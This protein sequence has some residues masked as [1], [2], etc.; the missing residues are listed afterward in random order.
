LSP[1]SGNGRSSSNHAPV[2]PGGRRRR[3]P[4]EA[5]KAHPDKPGRKLGKDYGS[6]AFRRLP[7]VRPD[8]II[9][10]PLAWR[11]PHCGAR[12]KE[13]YVASQFQT[14][15]PRRS[16]LRRFD[17]HIGEFM[18]CGKR[19]QPRHELRTSDTLG[20]AAVQIGPDAQALIA[21]LKA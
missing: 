18:S 13:D 8:E 3:S 17:L 5:P 21:L 6:Q 19:V 1:A 7:R 11:C 15:I 2:T 16:L 10:V 14:E 9:D 20:A 4:K 12:T